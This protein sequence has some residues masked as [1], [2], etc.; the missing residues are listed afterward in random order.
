MNSET[1]KHYAHHLGP[2]YSWMVGDFDTATKS[3]RE[4]FDSVELNPGPDSVAIDLGCGHGLQSVALAEKGFRVI[5]I[6]SCQLL[7][8]ELVSRS[9]SL[10]V[11]TVCDDL[12]NFGA[13]T[14]GLADAII[15][16]GDT[17]T[18]L[19]LE[20]D[21]EQLVHD[22][23]KTL[24]P[25]GRFCVSFRDYSGP[26]PEGT[27]R[28]IPVRSDDD[29]IQTCFLEYEAETIRVHDLIH[30]RSESSWDFS[31]SSYTKLRLS[32]DRLREIAT[33][34]QLLL[35]HES[36]NRGMLYMTFERATTG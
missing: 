6:D 16:M 1:T 11:T 10:S 20:S 30:S 22:V 14:N 5:G 34:N 4:Y 3:M 17:L 29:R 27:D 33:D 21:V 12:L 19:T 36:I 18:H 24:S 31:V 2:I 28:F 32:P 15:C 26:P 9:D 35:T 7:L 8:D 23:S 13:H 25:N